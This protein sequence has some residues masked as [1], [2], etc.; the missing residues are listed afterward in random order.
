MGF[1]TF[2]AIGSINE[3]IILTYT[4]DCVSVSYFQKS[5]SIFSESNYTQSF[6]MKGILK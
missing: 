3:S 1:V 6:S 5:V 2:W 4:L